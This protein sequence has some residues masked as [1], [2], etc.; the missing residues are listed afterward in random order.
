MTDLWLAVTT[1]NP[2]FGLP[3][4]FPE[5]AYKQLKAIPYPGPDWQDRLWYD[6]GLDVARCPRPGGPER[7]AGPGGRAVLRS[8]LGLSGRL[9]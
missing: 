8:R 1:G 2:R 6:F 4:F 9:L 7:P 3:A 5:A